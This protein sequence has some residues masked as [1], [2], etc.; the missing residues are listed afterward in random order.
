MPSINLNQKTLES[1]KPQI[2]RRDYWD[3]SLKGF[4]LRVSPDGTRV[5]SVYYRIGGKQRRK[6]LGEY[7]V[8]KLADARNRARADLDF[9]RRGIDPI[10]EQKRQEAAEVALRSQ[11]MTFNELAE[12]FLE[13]HVSKLR[14]KS[15]VRWA[16]E[17][18]LNPEFGKIRICDLK[19]AMI[20]EYLEAM[21]R[22]KPVLANR[23]LAYLRKMFNWALSHDFMDSTPCAGISR[24]GAEHQRD[25]VLTEDEIKAVWKGL[26]KEKPIM[27]ATFQLRLLTA[28]RGGE[29][30][31]M[32]W[33]DIDGE[34]WT[35]P[36][37]FSK[38]G[39]SHRV[40][41]SP[42]ALRVIEQVSRLTAEKDEKAGRKRS[43]WIFPNPIRRNEHITECQKLARRVR[44][45]SNVD[46]RAHD[47]RRTAASM[48]TGMGIPRLVVS[49]ILNHAEPG[50]TKVYDRHSYDKEKQE[51]LNA[52]G[53]R[54]SKILSDLELVKTEKK[55]A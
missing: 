39:L 16:F 7:P 46:F 17:Q 3:S 40:P 8:L 43:E 25:R 55:E 11:G 51:A 21:A 50:V 28:Q 48:M 14:S 15:V 5:F 13:A 26:N 45:E 33:A 23:L 18:R 27:A 38:N 36:A 22:T 20:R 32:K 12:K 6:T 31:T 37:E 54:L 24:P 1:L 29:V 30:H 10:E 19:R 9:V 4:V 35:I 44:K 34:W 41:L 52:W 42:Q 47:F 53:S 49:K 2:K